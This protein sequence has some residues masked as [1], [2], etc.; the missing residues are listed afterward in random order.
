MSWIVIKILIVCLNK[1]FSTLS[2]KLVAR[3]D[4]GGEVKGREGAE[5]WSTKKCTP[6]RWVSGGMPKYCFTCY[7][8][9][10]DVCFQQTRLYMMSHL[11]C[12]RADKTEMCVEN[13]FLLSY[14]PLCKLGGEGGGWRG[15][16]GEARRK[17]KVSQPAEG[18]SVRGP[19]ENFQ[20]SEHSPHPQ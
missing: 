18:R 7:I 15:K 20:T 14:S 9:F 16:R 17:M 10:V 19:K 2:F 13:H 12:T 1:Y 11:S 4:G 8:N 5:G 3:Q 6:R